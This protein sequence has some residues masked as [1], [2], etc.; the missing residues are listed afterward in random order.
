MDL[1]CADS[2]VQSLVLPNGGKKIFPHSILNKVTC[3]FSVLFSVVKPS[4]IV[5]KYV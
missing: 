3:P 2:Q 5:T 1:E 4:K